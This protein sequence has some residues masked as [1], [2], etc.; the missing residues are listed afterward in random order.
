MGGIGSGPQI[1]RKIWVEECLVLSAAALTRRRILRPDFKGTLPLRWWTEDGEVLT[2]W[3]VDVLTGVYAIQW[4]GQIEPIPPGERWP[5]H[6]I[7]LVT[8]PLPWGG[9]RF[10]FLCPLLGPN[11]DGCERRVDKLYLPR[12][13]QEFGCR[14]C[15]CLSYRSR[16]ESDRPDRL[17]RWLHRGLLD[18]D[19]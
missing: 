11:R 8:S 18:G 4:E 10:W 16:N 9:F 3:R 7:A 19:Q 2:E 13:C 14:H 12:G 15:H 17:L 6:S 5:L 1:A